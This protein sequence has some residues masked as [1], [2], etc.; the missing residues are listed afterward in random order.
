M[1][2]GHQAPKGDR[3]WK[4]GVN[5]LGQLVGRTLSQVSTTYNLCSKILH[6]RSKSDVGSLCSVA[7]ASGPGAS[8]RITG[9]SGLSPGKTQ[10]SFPF[11][12][13]FQEL[14]GPSDLSPPVPSLRLETRRAALQPW[15]ARLR[16]G[17]IPAGHR[18]RQPSH[19]KLVGT[20]P[21]LALEKATL[22]G[23]LG[24]GGQSQ[25]PSI[26]LA[27]MGTLPSCPKRGSPR[28][29]PVISGFVS[30]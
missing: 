12:I 9:K 6:Q 3:C 24:G 20:V 23:V 11:C 29:R 22:P 19:R 4:Q 2:W 17:H 10:K 27:V 15:A 14:P 8:L 26:F 5:G 1:R 21:S 28:A 7:S 30:T 13:Q 25:T 16:A 18:G